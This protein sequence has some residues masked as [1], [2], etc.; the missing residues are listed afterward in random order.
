MVILRISNKGK[1][2]NNLERFHIDN[3]TK[4]DNQIKEKYT[5][6]PY[7]IFD[8]LILKYN[9]TSQSQLRLPLPTVT[10]LS[11]K[12]QHNQ[13]ARVRLASQLHNKIVIIRT[14]SH[15]SYL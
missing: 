7:I 15:T 13:R 4:A 3:E 11:H 1:M 14:R 2:L 9:S 10:S 12:L 6:R 5:V 8:T